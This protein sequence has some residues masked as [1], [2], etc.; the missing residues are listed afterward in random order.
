MYVLLAPANSV[1]AGGRSE[2][3]RSKPTTVLSSRTASRSC[4]P[5]VMCAGSEGIKKGF[6]MNKSESSKKAQGTVQLARA[7]KQG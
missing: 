5:G 7:H 1:S 4:V 3:S 6:G 2:A